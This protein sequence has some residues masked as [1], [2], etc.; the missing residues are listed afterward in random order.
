MVGV[1]FFFRA[2]CGIRCGCVS[3]GLGDVYKVQ[4]KING[5]VG[6]AN[7]VLRGSLISRR[8]EGPRREGPGRYIAML[9]VPNHAAHGGSTLPFEEAKMLLAILPHEVL[10][11][12]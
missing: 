7:E 1:V 4:T 6:L 2:E 10:E 9:Q 3:R 5:I 8:W 12:S 11:K